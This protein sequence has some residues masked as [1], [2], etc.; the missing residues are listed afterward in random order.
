MSGVQ[1]S[2]LLRVRSG[3]ERVT[4]IELFFDLVYVFAITQLSHHLLGQ[5]TWEGAGQ[6]VLLLAAVWLAWVYTAAVTN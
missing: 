2:S 3:A 4:N 5:P 1:T 6:T